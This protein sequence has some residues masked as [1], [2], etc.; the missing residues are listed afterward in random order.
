MNKGDLISSIADEAGISKA[1][2]EKALSAFTNVV[3]NTLKAGD[4]VAISGF[5]T[6]SVSDRAE[7]QGRNPKTG[8]EI[9]IAASKAPKFKAGKGLKDSLNG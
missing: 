5:G 4:T 2:A 7:R 3:T 9:T 1:D 6:F 8:E